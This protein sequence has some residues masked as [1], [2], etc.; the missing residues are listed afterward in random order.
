MA[1]NK[2]EIEY[3][4]TERQSA[5]STARKFRIMAYEYKTK[6]EDAERRAEQCNKDA[7]WWEGK[8]KEAMS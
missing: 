5:L 6:A 3:F 8:I 7:E 2:E 1:K 4:E